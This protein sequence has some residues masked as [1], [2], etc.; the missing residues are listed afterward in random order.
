MLVFQDT[1]HTARQRDTGEGYSCFGTPG[2]L[3]A[4]GLG[5]WTPGALPFQMP[6]D[7]PTLFHGGG[8][9]VLQVHYHPTGKPGERPHAAWRCTSRRRLRRA[10]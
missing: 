5:G 10:A 6:D 1:T 9:I 7:I 2:F 4:R 8:D 3:P